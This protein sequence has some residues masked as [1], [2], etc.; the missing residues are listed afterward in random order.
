MRTNLEI[1]FAL[2]ELLDRQE[3]H[4]KALRRLRTA[5]LVSVCALAVALALT[6]LYA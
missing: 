1:E 3:R 6:P 4:S 5:W 2:D